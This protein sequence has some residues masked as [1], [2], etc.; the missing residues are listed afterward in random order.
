[1]DNTRNSSG[2]EEVDGE[3]RSGIGEG[4]EESG[5]DQRNN[6]LEIVAVSTIYI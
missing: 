1:M 5:D 6:V 2:T 4:V 3:E